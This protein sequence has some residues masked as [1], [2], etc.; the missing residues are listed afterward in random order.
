[1]NRIQFLKRIAGALGLA[2][3]AKEAVAEDEPMVMFGHRRMT[4][5]E[6]QKIRNYEHA[7]TMELC[8]GNFDVRCEEQRQ[9]DKEFMRGSQWEDK[10][11]PFKREDRA[12]YEL[13]RINR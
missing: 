1:M 7:R 5:K 6:A 4:L 10:P 12:K 9:A 11:F 2:V 8:A 3:V 13:N